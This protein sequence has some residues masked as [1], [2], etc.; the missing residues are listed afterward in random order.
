MPELDGYSATR[1]IRS[2]QLYS[3]PRTPEAATP[4]HAPTVPT[5]LQDIPIV[6]MTASAI[7]GDRE[8]CQEAGMDDYLAKP[9]RSATLEKMLL[10]WCVPKKKHNDQNGQGSIAVTEAGILE[11]PEIR[12]LVVIQRLPPDV[13]RASENGKAG[14]RN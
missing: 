12:D 10:K 1:I 7:R 5:W 8:K 3:Y 11:D 9:V 6:A 4:P 13:L 14:G 2:G